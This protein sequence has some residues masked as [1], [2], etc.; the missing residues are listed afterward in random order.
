MINIT[1]IRPLTIAD[2]DAL[3]TLWQRAGLS[4][5]PHGRDSR[6]AIARELARA[7]DSYL[8]LFVEGRL[9]ASIIATFDGRKGW[10]NRLAVDPDFRGKGYGRKLVA[11]AEEMLRETYGAPIIAALIEQDNAPSRRLFAK[12]GYAHGEHICYYSKREHPDV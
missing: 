3:I 9:A 10:I 2:Y 8:G 11:A 12:C 1:K 4:H 5:R 6:E 7:P